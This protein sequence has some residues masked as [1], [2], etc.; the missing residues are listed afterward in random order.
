MTIIIKASQ[1]NAF[2]QTGY[3]EVHST[4]NLTYG[5]KIYCFK[6]E[7]NQ[8]N[9]LKRVN[10]T[11]PQTNVDIFQMISQQKQNGGSHFQGT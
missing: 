8:Q 5:R 2:C 4:L 11:G 7:P 9:R 3:S 6:M 10:R 1:N